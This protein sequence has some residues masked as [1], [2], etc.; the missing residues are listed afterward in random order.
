MSA[1]GQNPQSKQHWAA[2]NE[3]GNALFLRLTTLMVR[4]LPAW[5]MQPCIFFVVA[6]F[7]LT[8]PQARQNVRRYQTQVQ[9]AYFG[10]FLP[11]FSVFKQFIAFGV[12]ICDRF[13]VWQ[14]KI[15]YRDLRVSDPNRISERV[16]AAAKRA[17]QR[18]EMFVCSH[19]GNME[20]CR[21]LVSHHQGF[22]LNV[23]VHSHHAKQ[24]NQALENAGAAR[25][26]LIQ[27]SD[28]DAAL[29]LELN[30]RLEAGEWLA[31]AADRVPIRGDKTV[32]VSFLDKMAEFP[33]GA[34]LLAILL[35]TPVHSLF[36]VKEDGQYHLKIQSYTGELGGKR[37]ERVSQ[38]QTAAQWFADVLGE[39]CRLQPL[40]WFNFYDFWNEKS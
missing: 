21:A 14:G 19:F 38:V 10:V 20:I 12:S 9:A 13:A 26:S 5:L 36:C 1:A 15:H 40:Q 31:I 16:D 23:L 11:K 34:W 30:R 33:Q 6:Y 28:L 8:S 2:Q 25:I 24:F 37:S 39:E 29:M 18:G 4:Y 22:K 27:V 17:G 3:R 32:S 35:K 7:Y